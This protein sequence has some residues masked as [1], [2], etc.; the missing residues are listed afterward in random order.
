MWPY[1]LEG[2]RWLLK[3]NQENPEALSPSVRAMLAVG[4]AQAVQP[5]Y[6]NR[7]DSASEKKG[8]PLATY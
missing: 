2:D 5:V 4:D 6:E 8:I 3:Y 7:V 1:H